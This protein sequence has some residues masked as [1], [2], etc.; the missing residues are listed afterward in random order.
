MQKLVGYFTV[1][2]IPKVRSASAMSRSGQET[3]P[4]THVCSRGDRGGV[5]GLGREEMWNGCFEV[6]VREGSTEGSRIGL[7]C[8]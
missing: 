3:F 6:Q 8:C 4:P 2:Y 1:E 5:G 7:K